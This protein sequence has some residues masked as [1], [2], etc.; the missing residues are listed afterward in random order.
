MKST[1]DNLG[2]GCSI[3]RRD[4]LHGFG[5]LTASA[6]V[7]GPLGSL[8]E[9]MAAD[10]IKSEGLNAVYPPAK[11]GLRGNHQGSFE[12]AHQ[13]ARSGRNN[14]GPVKQP[15]KPYDLVVVGAGISGLSS[16][17]F[18]R[19]KHPKARILILDNHDDFGGHAKRNEFQAPGKT[20]IGYGGAQTLQE[21]S[22]YSN[23]VKEL[24]SDLGVKL[25]SFDTAYDQDFYHRHGLS[26]ALHFNQED[27]GVDRTIP[28]DQPGVYEGYIPIA[29]SSLSTKDAVA[30]MPISELAKVEYE[31]LFSINEDQIP[32]IPS[33][34]KRRFL[35]SI[36]YRDFISKYLNIKQPD[37]FK[38]LQNMTSDFGVG[39]EAVSAYLAMSYSGLPGLGA[40]GLEDEEDIEPY[41]HHFPDG[42][43]SIARLLVR[44]MI[45]GVAQGDSMT[46]I[47]TAVFDYSKLDLLS[48]S[49]RLRLNSTVTQ[50]QNHGEHK[51]AKHVEVSYV[52]NNQAYSV[53]ANNCVLACNNSMIPYLCPEMPKP[54]RD[55]LA[56]QVK[57]PILYTSVLLRNW[58]ACK[59]LGIGAIYSPSS[60]HVYSTIDFPV[61][62]GNYKYSAGPDEP[63]IMHMERFPHRSNEGLTPS[64]Q[65][66]LGRHELLSTS[67][68]TIERSVRKQLLSMLG[69][70]GFDPAIDILGITV[71]RWAHGY[72]TSYNPLFDE[73]YDEW[74]D[75]RYPHVQARK[76]FGRIT[77]AN[78]DSDANAMFE[79]A[80]EQAYRAVTELT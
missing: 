1:D 10:S 17:H 29:A 42:N 21:P 60:Y 64:Q 23:V 20:I 68:E 4:I 52:L 56:K 61:S 65:Y 16:A 57:T 39:I 34:D 53:K 24:L 70:G 2:M 18:Y 14:W 48:S 43:A 27:W 13:L 25:K 74:D 78:A 8:S 33:G 28:I 66:R 22:S 73:T 63:V 79:A 40:T 45:S 67:F 36:S 37:V 62:I 77:I 80:V 59:K 11:T 38:I 54:Q 30:K 47:V 15:D 35:S 72:A 3:S 44:E 51:N 69:D 12:V 31:R 5:S 46:D 19:K 55:A 9:L 71:N 50:V 49:V 41:I 32:H 75:P 58:H 7:A 6:L 26:S 76:P